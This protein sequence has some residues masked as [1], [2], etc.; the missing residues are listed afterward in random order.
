[1]V[2]GRAGTE[3]SRQARELRNTLGG[4]VI[5]LFVGFILGS[6]ATT[7]LFFR[8]VPGQGPG[9]NFFMLPLLF[10]GSIVLGWAVGSG[11]GSRLPIRDV[12]PEA[13][14]SPER[15]TRRLRAAR[16][17]V[18][19]GLFGGFLGGFVLFSASKILLGWKLEFGVEGA[20]M[21]G[22]SFGGALVGAVICGTLVNRLYRRRQSGN[23]P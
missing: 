19:F 8:L 22:S 2:P 21:C 17:G 7:F 1:M 6:M 12:P 9:V 13:A 18:V 20:L 16:Q 10:F 23:P 15:R 5:G 11:I 14:E 4:G 3:G